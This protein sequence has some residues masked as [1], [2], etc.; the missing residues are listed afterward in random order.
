MTPRV[1]QGTWEEIAA[2]A[3]E[4]RRQ[5]RLF[6]I[7]PAEEDP[8]ATGGVRPGLSPQ[9][10]IARLNALAEQNRDL[11]VLPPEAFERESLYDEGA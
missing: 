4:L 7:V 10:R 9:E 3:D 8:P 11:P 6:L 5:Q 2:H 1:L